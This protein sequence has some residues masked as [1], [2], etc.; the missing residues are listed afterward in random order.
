MVPADAEFKDAG[1]SLAADWTDTQSFSRLRPRGVLGHR[2]NNLSRSED[3]LYWGKYS[4][5]G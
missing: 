5:I 1:L 2:K 3:E 4:E